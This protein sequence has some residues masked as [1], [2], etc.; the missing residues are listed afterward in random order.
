[1]NPVMSHNPEEPSLEIKLKI[2]FKIDCF[3]KELEEY[4][5]I[6][7]AASAEPMVYISTIVAELRKIR[8]NA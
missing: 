2:E 6:K 8:G 7:I 3:I 5:T 1:M 4:E